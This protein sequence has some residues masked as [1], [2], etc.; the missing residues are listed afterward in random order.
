MTD[1]NFPVVA[2]VKVMCCVD[3]PGAIK[4][5][6]I[7]RKYLEQIPKRSREEL[8]EHVLSVE[9]CEVLGVAEGHVVFVDSDGKLF[10]SHQME[11]VQW[12]GQ[13]CDDLAKRNELAWAQLASYPQLF[14][15]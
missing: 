5:Q 15:D 1:H 13:E 14:A 12:L 6:T 7:K 8:A 11:W 9:D 4:L 2:G 10:Q 3:N